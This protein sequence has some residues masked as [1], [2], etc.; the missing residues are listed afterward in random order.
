MLQMIWATGRVDATP[1]DYFPATEA[2][3]AVMPLSPAPLRPLAEKLVTVKA[4]TEGKA[5][6]VVRLN[7][8]VTNSPRLNPSPFAMMM[9]NF[10]GTPIDAGVYLA[11]AALL[12]P[13][14]A[15]PEI[16]TTPSAVTPVSG[17]AVT[18]IPSSRLID[19]SMPAMTD[20]VPAVLSLSSPPVGV[21]RGAMV[22]PVLFL[23]L[24]LKFAMALFIVEMDSDEKPPPCSCS[25][26]I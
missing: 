1:H 2:G 4:F 14:A 11:T 9:C 7:W 12:V 20:A 23:P 5:A 22:L 6:P 17:S 16:V 19:R 24:S 18:I 15:P 25:S 21:G 3:A 10:A 26:P 13:T 8:I